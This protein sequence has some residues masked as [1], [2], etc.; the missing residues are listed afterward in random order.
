MAHAALGSDAFGPMPTL[1]P[2]LTAPK[3]PVIEASLRSIG[4]ELKHAI[5][6][7]LGARTHS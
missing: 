5:N 2:P 7:H 3:S 6:P 1:E 4:D